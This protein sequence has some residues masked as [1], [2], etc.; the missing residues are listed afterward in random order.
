MRC[1]DHKFDPILQKDYYRLQAFFT[2]LLPRDDLTAATARQY[3]DYQA[4]PP[5]GRRRP[6]KSFAKSTPSNSPIATREPPPQLPSS[7]TKSSGF[8]P[9]PKKTGPRWSN[10]LAPCA[11]RQIR[12][13]HDQVPSVLKGA[14]KARWNELREVLKR[15]EAL[16]PISPD[17]VMTA[18]DLGPVSPPTVIP[19]DRKQ[20]SSSPAICRCFPRG[21]LIS[22]RRTEAAIHGAAADPGSL[23]RPA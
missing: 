12:F 23:A 9:S 8:S 5:P 3:A 20:R 6:L 15:Y 22:P 21:R 16:R 10:S 11:F 7:L 13:E 17:A 18:T 19:G 14:E 2:P 4:K 1:H